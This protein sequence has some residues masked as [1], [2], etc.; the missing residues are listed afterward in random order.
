MRYCVAFFYLLKQNK[1]KQLCKS[2]SAITRRGAI[3]EGCILAK[4]ITQRGKQN[5]EIIFNT[6]CKQK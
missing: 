3:K 1:M 5:S 4:F 2:L 6:D